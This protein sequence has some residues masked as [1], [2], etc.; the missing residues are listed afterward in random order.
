MIITLYSLSGLYMCGDT[1]TESRHDCVCGEVT[2]THGDHWHHYCCLEAGHR[3]D[4]P[5]IN[6]ETR[7][8]TS[9]P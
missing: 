1:C 8:L 3:C 9:I 7:I 6:K 4:K 5:D 2:L